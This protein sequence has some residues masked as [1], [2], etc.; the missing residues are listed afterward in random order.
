M[1]VKHRDSGKTQS[2]PPAWTL[3]SSITLSQHLSGLQ[4]LYLS[5]GDNHQRLPSTDFMPGTGL[6]TFICYFI[7]LYDDPFFRR[8]N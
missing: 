1:K 4:F 3:P 2:A 5:N 6:N 8:G 7:Q